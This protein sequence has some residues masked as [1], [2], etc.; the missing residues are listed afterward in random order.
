MKAKRLMALLMC[1]LTVI[2]LIPGAAF[3]AQS[4]V[5]IESQTNSAFDYLEY[6]KDG[7]WKDLNTPRHWIEQ[8]GEVVYCVEHAAGNPHGDTY[9]AASP[10]SVFSASTLSGLNSILMYG[11]PNNRP[12]GFTDDE[13]RQA[14]AN[15]IRFWLSEQG[16]AESYSFTNRRTNPDAIRAKSGYEH[17]LEYA[18]ELLAKARA[19]QELPHSI[20]FSTSTVQLTANG[21][22]FSGQT[23][24][25]LTNINS[26]YTLDTS[27]LPA[28]ASVSGYTGSRSETLTITVPASAAG[29]SFSISAEGKDTRSVDNITAY[30][31]ANGSLQKIFLCATTAQVVATASFNV[32]IPAYGKVQVVKTGE[33]GTALAGV[34]FG[35]YFDSDCKN[36]IAELTTGKDGTGTSGDIPVGTVYLKELSTVSPYIISTEV[37]SATI[38][39]N[40]VTKVSFTNVAAKGKIRV[41]KVGDVLTGSKSEET[42][43]GNITVPAY[44]EKGLRGVVYEVRDSMGKVVATLTTDDS[45]V[46][47]TEALPLGGYTAQ[48]KDAPAAYIVDDTVHEVT[49]AYKD[50]NTPVV[51]VTVKADN[52]LRTGGVKIRKITEKFNYENIDFYNALAEGYVFGLY[53]A[54]TIGDIPAD[55]LLEVLTT[56][57]QGVAQTSVPLPYGKYYLRELAVPLETIEMLTDQ[58]PLTISSELN[59]QHYDS[60]I[61]NT[62]FKTRIGVYKLDEADTERTLAGAVFEVRDAS[63][64]LFD[65]ITTNK[66]GYAETI[67]IPVG[68]YKVKEIQPPAGFIL[69]DEVKTVTLTTKDKE[70]AVFELTNKAN[71]VKVRKLDSHTKQPLANADIKV[72]DA[73][74]DVFFEG[75]TGTDGYINMIEL[76]AGKYTWQEVVAPEAY[77]I[78]PA[79]YSFTIDAYGKVAGDVQFA[80]DPITLEILK[81]NTYTGAPM[82]GITFTL[83]DSEGKV[84]K[85]KQTDDGYRIPAED[86]TETFVTDANGKAV[87]KYLKVGKYKLVEAVPVGYIADGTTE[88]E[89]TDKHS[90]AAPCKVTVNNCPTGVKIIKLDAKTEKPLTGAGFSIKVKDGLGFETLTFTKQAD[91]KY[92]FDEN[93]KEMDLMVDK[94][95]EVVILGLPMGAIW[96]EES[97]VPTGYFPVTARKAEITKETSAVKPIEIKVPNNRSVALGMDNDRWELPAMIAGALLLLGGAA[98]LVIK[99]RKKLK[100]SEE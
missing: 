13:A 69:Y 63:G 99:R 51:T 70:T 44:T 16:E 95:G 1:L 31:P 88:I 36:K 19:R 21:S 66:D 18:D 3:A 84:V 67:E 40:A 83:Q 78:D 30:I 47:E 22:G 89:L 10:S 45:G 37:K 59:V 15:A 4:T 43:Y 58:L 55:V 74:G 54:E 91:G 26:G 29:Q 94:N 81:M 53:T 62:M 11:Y 5:T 49:L 85:T 60:P 56:D 14:T 87:F 12:S 42:E 100:G 80:N 38:T 20:D 7:A 86:G 9:T 76:P 90:E 65:T 8:T 48:E 73:S 34:K 75:K 77:S 23:S 28:G 24:V 52:E 79:L 2:G 41:E 46:A 50:Q 25:R 39:A 64:K 61:Y 98:F 97:V 6:Y 96:I 57:D 33:D 27:A 35:V 68:V 93:G 32:G 72:T 92:F 71:E 17:V 82:A